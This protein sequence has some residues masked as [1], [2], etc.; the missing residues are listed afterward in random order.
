MIEGAQEMEISKASVEV[1][2]KVKEKRGYLLPYHELFGCMDPQLLEK[3]DAFYTEVTLKAKA[4]DN[5][6]KELVWIGILAGASEEAGTIHLR[7]AREAGVTDEEISEVMVITQVAKGFDVL[8]FVEGK[9]GSFLT[10]I[11]P[12]EVY[13]NFVKHLKK[14]LR[15][16]GK[17]VELIFVGI[18]AALEIKNGL[19]FHLVE[20]KGC[21]ASDEEIAEAMSFII[22]PR[23]GNTLLKAAEV[24]KDLVKEGRLKP[25]SIFKYWLSDDEA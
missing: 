15:L 23:G 10:E 13:E 22:I 12:M 9:W 8:L 7:R 11:K 24:L 2:K 5:R 25:G 18:Y 21:G 3:Y 16:P 19:Q 1:L 20:A 14:G 17:T 4:L 6:T